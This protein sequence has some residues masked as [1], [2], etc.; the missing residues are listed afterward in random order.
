ML[1]TPA[2]SGFAKLH[3]AGFAAQL[4]GCERVHRDARGTDGVPLG[5]ESARPVDGQLA[6]GSDQALVQDAMSLAGCGESRPRTG[7][8]PRFFPLGESEGLV[9]EQFCDRE[10]VVGFQQV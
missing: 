10:A 5:L 4:H 3:V 9:L 6:V 7:S 1:K 2:S 8:A